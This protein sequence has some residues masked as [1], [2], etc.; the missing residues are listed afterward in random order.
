MSE[1]K[2]PSQRTS[3]ESGTRKPHPGPAL[4]P[5]DPVASIVTAFREA[6]ARAPSA[7]ALRGASEALSYAELERRSNQM[8]HALVARGVMPGAHVA[9]LADRGVETIVAFLAI[10]KAGAAYAP[11][12]PSYPDEQLA[13]MLA[14]L[15]PAFVL[16]SAQY[17]DRAD[18]VVAL[19]AFAR[20]AAAFP[21]DAF[22]CSAGA[23]SA[24]YVMYTSG[25]TGR[26]KGV[27]ATHRG[28][29]RLVR[30]QDYAS[31]AQDE[32]F[33]HL[34]PLPFD[35]STF[36]IW[37]A[38]LNGA[39]VAI[40][41]APRPSLDDICDAIAQF[42]AT[43]AWFTAGLFHV[44]VDHKLEGLAP[45]RQIL[46]GGDVL[47]PD[48]TQRALQ[49]LPHCRLINGY[50]PTE[51]TTF[52][53][54]HT[55]SLSETG[56][57]PIGR[58][59]AH[60]RVTVR[61]E[62]LRPVAEGETG[63]LCI[64]GDGLAL[65]YLN[66]PELTAEK[67]V[68][69]P[70]N[71]DE[72]LYLSGDL[73]RETDGVFA[74]L[75][76]ADAQV[77]IDGKRVDL[78]EIESWL[79]QHP[80]IVDAAVTARAQ[81][82][83]KRIVAF[84]V[85]ANTWA[86]GDDRVVRDWLRARVPAHMLPSSITPLPALPLNANGKVDRKALPEPEAQSVS[87]SAIATGALAQVRAA[88]AAVLELSPEAISPD[89]NFFDLGG[90][91]LRLLEAHARLQTAL[92]RKIDLVK[93]FEHTS[94]AAL[95]AW[96]DGAKAQPDARRAQRLATRSNDIAII[97]M[98][99]RFPGA[100]NVNAFW[101]NICAG[102]DT[103]SRFGDDELEDAFDAATRASPNFVKAR[104][105]L[106]GPELF[107]A[108]FFG[109]YPREAALTDPQHRV[110]LEIAWAALEDAG[111][112]P[113]AAPGRVGV[114][115]GASMNTYFL[116]Q[117]ASD[118]AELSSFT[119]DYQVGSYPVLMG[120]LQ[121]TL[122]TRVAYKL[123][124]RGPAV[125]VQSA[126]S[127]SLLAI[128]QACQSLITGQS[129]MALAGGVSITFP[130]KR[131][132]LA[133]D[134]GL[135]S[136]DGYCRPFDAR[137]T[138]TVFGS[139]AAAILLK[140][141]DDALADGDHVYAVIRGTGVNN[142]GA[143][144]VGFTAP[145][146]EGQADAIADALAFAGVDPA[147]IGYVECHGTATP[148]GDPIEFEGLRQTYGA[149]AR[150]APC[151]LGSAKANVGHLDAAA[152]VTG[153]IK[154][155]LMLKHRAIPP[156]T[157]FEAPNPRLPDAQDFYFPTALTP[158]EGASP[159]RAGV[160]SFGVGGTN[161][162][163]VL[164][165]APR[166]EQREAS[167]QAEV[168]VLS[169]RSEDAVTAMAADL[170]AFLETPEAP[171]LADVAHTLQSGRRSFAHRLAISASSTAE[172]A[173]ALRVAKP[174]RASDAPPVVFLFP[175]QGA[176]YAGMARAPYAQHAVFRAVIDAGAALVAPLIGEDLRALL[177]AEQPTDADEARLKETRRAQPALYLMEVAL[178]KL[179]MSWGVQ[180]AAMVGHSI[181][182]FAA[183]W[184]SQR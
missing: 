183:T 28:V 105:V 160:S 54:C 86:A 148:L 90:T 74:F 163:A 121:D 65:G 79:R 21:D 171:P 107:D 118:P 136:T 80:A 126:C 167:A 117:I 132:Y 102:A 179:W 92:D 181:G 61:D 46:A 165:E 77:K 99:G 155:A 101:E 166:A 128:A 180:P 62:A 72:R 18:G 142:D 151:A 63:Q 15:A 104:S 75:G 67:F 78:G 113:L 2:S 172:A 84:V 114:F 145:S 184:T 31:F 96:L 7:R 53:C 81:G 124:L 134:G 111:Y 39:E 138:G 14:D 133:L 108:E 152:G 106:D 40:V 16:A 109:M 51:S 19:N 42:G 123:N 146:V 36:E 13:Y 130:Q 60:T 122:A 127:T 169:A 3:R 174:A 73:V 87:Q 173:Q 120:A 48:H 135:A 58:A 156:L 100:R 143:R 115:A 47:S 17:C 178:A 162:H 94:A 170:A 97:G 56:A 147:T 83:L 41:E 95:A 34:A 161:V 27:I 91:S 116:N 70:L 139:G 150:A 68:I 4:L 140:R 141:R 30:G 119:N 168:L 9:V 10:L 59:I 129:D 8:A 66:A 1:G 50:G 176:Q 164:E 49:A 158:W 29:T 44:L 5:Y 182:E 112:D 71:P 89:A 149:A 33:L 103:I 12:D 43:T 144:K 52:T 93:L 57:V 26:P 154:A 157:H 38:L 69:D 55:L 11:L 98:A 110:F 76:R 22:A 25:S 131:G 153:V 6:V 177:V 20:E 82:A 24:A 125:N 37:G 88:W 35:A 32:V 175:G 137:A 159:R 45:L 23:E 85:P 64:G